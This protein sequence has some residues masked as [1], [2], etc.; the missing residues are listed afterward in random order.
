M[1]KVMIRRRGDGA[2]ARMTDIQSEIPAPPGPEPSPS[3]PPIEDP[4]I[5]DPPPEGP[6]V[7]VGDPSRM[8]EVRAATSGK[9]AARDPL[10]EGDQLASDRDLGGRKTPS[11]A[12]ATALRGPRRPMS[13]ARGHRASPIPRGPTRTRPTRP[14][15]TDPGHAGVRRM[16]ARRAPVRRAPSLEPPPPRG[17]GSPEHAG[18]YTAGVPSG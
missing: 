14:P 15:R 17:G 7:P 16:N 11:P 9:E 18:Q 3:P 8:P 13:P 6:G 1:R 10:S 4:P 2:C 12:P 5:G